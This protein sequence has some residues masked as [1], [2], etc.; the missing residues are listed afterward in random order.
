MRMIMFSS[1]FLK[2]IL[3]FFHK[4]MKSIKFLESFWYWQFEWFYMKNEILTNDQS[5]KLL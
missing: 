2:I 4:G 3:F 1:L 5:K